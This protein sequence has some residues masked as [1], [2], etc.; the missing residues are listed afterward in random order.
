M[1]KPR[2]LKGF[3]L[4]ELLVVIALLA[5]ITTGVI[6]LLNP[7]YLI[8]KS[9][10]GKRKSDLYQIQSALQ[11]YITDVGTYPA[12]VTC[13]GSIANG[14]NT[15]LQ[16]VPCDPKYGGTSTWNY[17]YSTPTTTTYVLYTCLQTSNDPQKDAVKGANCG[18][19]SP[20]SFTVRNP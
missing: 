12:S 8:G 2:V 3:T 19:D 6:L 17:H 11:M 9:N 20:A 18:T 14:S 4:V 10:D 7:A 16:K 5:V 13:G 1:K 15:Y